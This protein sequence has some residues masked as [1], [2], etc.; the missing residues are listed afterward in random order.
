MRWNIK[1]W[2]KFHVVVWRIEAWAVEEVEHLNVK[3][4]PKALADFEILE[5]AHIH[6]GLE[7]T[8]ED[9]AAGWA[10]TGFPAGPPALYR[11]PRFP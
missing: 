8:S 7:R 11:I 9:V 2:I 4:Q 6:A 10:E 5:D 1:G 3:F